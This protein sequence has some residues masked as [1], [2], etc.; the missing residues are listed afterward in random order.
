VLNLQLIPLESQS[1]FI[2]DPLP[3]PVRRAGPLL[4]VIMDGVG[5]GDRGAGDGYHLAKK[6]TLD[7]LS[8]W[9]KERSLYTQL[10][11]HGR[12]VG[13]PS[14]KDIGNSEVGHNAMGAGRVF[15]QGAELV[16]RAIENGKIFS[17][18]VWKRLTN[19]DKKHS[20]HLIGLLSDGNVHSHINHLF[21]LLD[22][23]A[24]IH[25][26]KVRVH[27]LLDGRDVSERSALMY[28][29]PLEEHLRT[30]GNKK[31][32]DFKIASGGGRMRVTMDRY[33][34]DWKVVQRGWDAQVRGI[35][36]MSGA[37]PGYFPSGSAAIETAR[38]IYPDL[39]DQYLPSFVVVDKKEKPVGTIKDGDSVVFFNF[40][41]D[42]ALQVSKAFTEAKFSKFDRVSF[43]NVTFAGMLEYDHEERI[44]N[45]YLVNPPEIDRT[46]GE[47]L[48]AAGVHQYACAETHK[49]GHVT[50][51]W[52]GNRTGYLDPTLEVYHE[53]PS[54]PT[55][56][57][58]R[59]PAMKALEVGNAIGTAM[60]SRKHSFLRVNFANGD[61]AGHTGVLDVT[62]KS[63]E[64]MDHAIGLLKEKTDKLSGVMLITSDHGNAEEKFEANG[65]P[66]T[67][68]TL[69]PVP[70]IVYD[71]GYRKEYFLAPH[72]ERQLA[73]IA[74]TV[75]WFL[76]FSPPN[77]YLPS[78][79]TM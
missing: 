57:I 78:L 66:K 49:F 43:P 2:L 36:E 50:Y 9:A 71:P 31:N 73:N 4:L 46:L 58:T 21:A 20:F 15:S 19:I 67:S 33:E 17:T 40:R 3:S 41:G 47:Y 1:S 75:L 59:K 23:L 64:A 29:K 34:S 62:I 26:Q 79:V 65:R 61:M 77:G 52:N 11:A 70:F 60:E 76:G 44:P 48:C 68:H 37:Y 8:N 35:P 55:E 38:R 63:I 74:S 27:T 56:F 72:S 7:F 53:V 24:R 10:K 30:L 51:F 18:D 45:L 5:I 14:D 13:L 69:N 25:I 32:I 12:A 6:P 28:I 22:E 39:N 42:R 54:D 16:N